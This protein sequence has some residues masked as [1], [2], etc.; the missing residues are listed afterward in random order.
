MKGHK[1][2]T[3]AQVG[4]HAIVSLNDI[5]KLVPAIM[6]TKQLAPLVHGVRADGLG[7][8]YGREIVDRLLLEAGAKKVFLD[9]NDPAFEGRIQLGEE[10]TKAKSAT[11]ALSTALYKLRLE[12]E[13]MT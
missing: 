7:K 8:I 5:D 11:D 6:L 4:D 12:L 3:D 1:E 9:G 2:L 13:T 10:I